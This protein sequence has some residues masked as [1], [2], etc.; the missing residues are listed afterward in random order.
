MAVYRYRDAAGDELQIHP[1][2]LPDRTTY[3]ALKVQIGIELVYLPDDEIP[4]LVSALQNY[5][6]RRAKE[7]TRAAR[8]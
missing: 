1:V 7:I 4:S 2:T 5:M 6:S 3:A 8:T